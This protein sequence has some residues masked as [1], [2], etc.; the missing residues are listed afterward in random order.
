MNGTLMGQTTPA[1]THRTVAAIPKVFELS[2]ISERGKFV[3]QY[4]CHVVALEHRH[5]DVKLLLVLNVY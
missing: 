2:K 4:L 1:K 3:H 5:V